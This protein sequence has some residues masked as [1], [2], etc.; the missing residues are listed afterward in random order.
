MMKIERVQLSVIKMALKSP[1]E[2]ALEKVVEREAIMLEVTD[3][4]G[5]TGYG[6]AIAFSTP[7]YTEETVRTCFHILKDVLIPLL[8][9]K[10]IF[11]PKEVSERFRAVRRNHM[12][13]AGI[14]TA[15]W[16]L[17]A[18]KKG[19]PLWKLIGGTR[20]TVAAGVA[21]G[22][23]DT[24]EALRQIESFLGD[25]YE[26]VKVKIKP[27]H[28]ESFIRE[29]RRNFPDLALMADANSAYTLEDLPQL[30]KLDRY[31][32]MMIEQP[33]AADDIVDHALLQK[34]LK[35][36]VCLDESIV[37]YHDAESAL[38]LGSFRVLNIKIG[39][40]GGLW[41]AIRLHDLC[42][43]RG[44]PVWCGGM[45]EFGISRAFNLALASLPGFTIP[46]DISASSRFWEKDIIVPEIKVENGK[47][48]LSNESGI[49][50]GLNQAYMEKVRIYK[51]VF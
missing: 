17:Y 44:I 34:Q 48:Q 33:L 38:R 1:F 6:E 15:I 16:D 7:W 51:E 23:H 4:D 10:P 40:V 47:I 42:A 8:M 5:V 9:K 19:I 30:E 37:T 41:P 14:E 29:I 13:K 12:A 25:G 39:R 24:A 46:G 45:I 20:E 31:G 11:H 22:S 18:K 36:P 27:G 21:V 43:A 3:K 2:N 32:L 28:D 49:G 50:F 26:R 35:T